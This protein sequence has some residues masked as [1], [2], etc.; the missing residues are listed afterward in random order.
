MLRH[1]RINASINLG[2]F[3]CGNAVMNDYFH[4]YAKEN[5]RRGISSCHLFFDDVERLVGYLCWN[6]SS[7]GKAGL[8]P[9]EAK[10]LPGYPIPAILISRLAIDT[11]QQRIGYGAY[12]LAFALD[13]A[14]V[15]SQSDTAPGFRFVVVDAINDLA[16]EFYK[17]FGFQSFTDQPNR[18]YLAIETYAK[19][20]ATIN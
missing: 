11:R 9:K 13:A 16:T 15:M 6:N 7:F 17:K 1:Q 3:D 8:P 18:L 19:A 12:L 20:K 4:K 14:L 2:D 5:D 10:G